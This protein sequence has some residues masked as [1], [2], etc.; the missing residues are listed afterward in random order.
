MQI[1]RKTGLKQRHHNEQKAQTQ[2]NQ[3]LRIR[4]RRATVVQA[5]RLDSGVRPLSRYGLEDKMKGLEVQITKN[6]HENPLKS[7]IA[8]LNVL[9]ER[10]C[11]MD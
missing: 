4:A 2:R 6:C 5:S 9:D 11:T 8:K 3:E 7:H 10:V 1:A